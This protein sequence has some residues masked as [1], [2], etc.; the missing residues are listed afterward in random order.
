MTDKKLLLVTATVFE[1]QPTIEYFTGNAQQLERLGVPGTC[2]E[3]EGFD[4]LVTGVG[5]LQCAA[6]L[7]A[8]LTTTSYRAVVQAGLAGS[9]S[10]T[11]PERSLVR[12]REEV[13]G[14]FGSEAD[15]SFL[16]MGD[17]GLLPRN[18]LP[19]RNGVLSVVEPDDLKLADLPQVRAVT[20]NRTLADLKSIEWVRQRYAPDIVN[21]EGAALFYVC[22]LQEV[23]F[24]ELRAVSDMVGPRDKASWDVNGS[25]AAL[26]RRLIDIL[27]ADDN[28][29]AT[30][31]DFTGPK[32][33]P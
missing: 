8:R 5:Q 4:C 21:M 19:F 31:G 18:Q 20:V 33:V 14:D 6:Q 28:R 25:I 17:I 29:P 1:V 3:H 11:Y 26:N 7:M 23:P 2:F 9:F 12:V 15:G 16:D 24:V 13:L 22:L 10:P 30:I 32:Q 27:I